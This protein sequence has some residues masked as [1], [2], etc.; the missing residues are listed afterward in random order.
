MMVVRIVM[1]VHNHKTH[2]SYLLHR[3]QVAGMFDCVVREYHVYCHKDDKT[4]AVKS[5]VACY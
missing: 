5:T 4:D 1:T 2:K 3:K